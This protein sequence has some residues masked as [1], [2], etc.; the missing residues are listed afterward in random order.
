MSANY[1]GLTRSEDG[2][3]GRWQDTDGDD[4]S[5]ADDD[6]GGL[7]LEM[8]LYISFVVILFFYPLWRWVRAKY[9]SVL[10][11]KLSESFKRMSERLSDS[12]V[13]L[14]SS[15]TTPLCWRQILFLHR[16]KLYGQMRLSGAGRK[17]SGRVS[18]AGR[19]MS[20]G[21]RKASSNI[22]RL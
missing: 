22:G 6:G 14:F 21:D 7:G 18:G 10:E 2:T 12:K 9:I 4:M 15:V 19:K 3:V 8:T 11:A 20:G 13:G 5:A 17:L 1:G 16:M